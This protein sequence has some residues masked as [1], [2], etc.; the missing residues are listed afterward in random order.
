VSEEDEVN[1]VTPVGQEELEE[2]SPAV[3]C[4]GVN[5]IL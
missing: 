4:V 1:E 2:T 5:A 3:E